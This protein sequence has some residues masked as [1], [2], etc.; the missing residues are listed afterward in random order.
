[1]G[2]VLDFAHPELVEGFSSYSTVAVKNERCFDK[3]SMSGLGAFEY[4]TELP[5]PG[6]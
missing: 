6:L 5:D 4:L 3:L 2:D 1:L